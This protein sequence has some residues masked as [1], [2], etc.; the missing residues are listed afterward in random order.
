MLTKRPVLVDVDGVLAD[1]IGKVLT[2]INIRKTRREGVLDVTC[3]SY[4]EIKT[5]IRKQ[6]KSEWDEEM[7][8][9]VR[10]PGFCKTL[11]VFL[12]SQKFIE[13]LRSTDRR[14]VFCTSPYKDSPTW[15]HDRGVWLKENFG[16]TRDDII[17]AHDKRFVNGIVLID[18]LPK[19]IEDWSEYNETG[20]LGQAVIPVLFKQPWNEKGVKE[21][22]SYKVFHTSDYDYIADIVKRLT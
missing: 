14:I 13:D 2:K 7:E 3:T 12:G 20:K 5:D 21:S 17:F 15:A 16:A 18:D 1:F 19:N 11:P 8:S 22:L 6:L 9:L 10:S 4:D